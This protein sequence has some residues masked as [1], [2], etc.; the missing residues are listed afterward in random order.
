MHQLVAQQDIL[1]RSQYK[2]RSGCSASGSLRRI[3][4]SRW[5]NGKKEKMAMK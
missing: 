5:M 3:F 1:Q 4:R 2:R